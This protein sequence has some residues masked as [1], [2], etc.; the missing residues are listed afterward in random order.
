MAYDVIDA[1]ASMTIYGCMA[2]ARRKFK[3]CY[4]YE[5]EK[6]EHAI[7]EIGKLY[8]KERRLRETGA[9]AEHRRE[10]RQK[11]ARPRLEALTLNQLALSS[12]SIPVVQRNHAYRAPQCLAR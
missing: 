1:H 6:A 3:D 10:V 4:K 7:T 5:P 9:V 12:C 8:A 2:H 11:K